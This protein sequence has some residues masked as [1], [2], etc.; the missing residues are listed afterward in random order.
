[1]ADYV[2]EAGRGGLNRLSRQDLE[3]RF[4]SYFG[5]VRYSLWDDLEP[6]HVSISP[7]RSQA[8]MA[9]V[10][11]ARLT[12]T[13]DDGQ[14]HEHAFESSWIAIYERREDDWQ[15]VGISSSVVD[16]T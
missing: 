9:V 11:E 7:D 14:A 5:T 12:Q 16:R 13:G 1:M 6:P 2:W 8:W 15:L 3:Q 4:A 10:I